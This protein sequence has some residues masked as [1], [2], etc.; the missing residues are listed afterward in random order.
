MLGQPQKAARDAQTLGMLSAL[1]ASN[2]K[3]IGGEAERLVPFQ[4]PSH[5]APQRATGTHLAPELQ[6]N[7][8][9][10]GA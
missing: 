8:V 2:R 4:S 5:S 3:L 9:H 7:L 10:G 6:H 1:A